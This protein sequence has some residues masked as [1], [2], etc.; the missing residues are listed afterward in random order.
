[1]SQ[2]QA[3]LSRRDSVE[4]ARRF[5]AGNRVGCAPRPAGTAENTR[6]IQPSLRDSAHFAS[7]PGVETPGYCQSSFQDKKPSRI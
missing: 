5:N 6:Q 2:A 3:N 7:Q 1:M 4:I